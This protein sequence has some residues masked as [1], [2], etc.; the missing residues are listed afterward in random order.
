MKGH[1]EKALG[2]SNEDKRRRA[3]GCWGA[4]GSAD[5]APG[6]WFWLRP[7]SQGPEEGP[8]SGLHIQWGVCWRV[9]LSLS[10][11]ALPHARSPFLSK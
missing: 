10:P 4:G 9:S 3:E 11:P 7:R 6:S 2:R 8:Y 5:W 1:T